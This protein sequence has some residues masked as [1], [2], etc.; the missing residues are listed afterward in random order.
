MERSEF[1][2]KLGIGMAVVCAGCA[3][4]VGAVDRESAVGERDGIAR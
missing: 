4:S 1:L 2:S 3:I